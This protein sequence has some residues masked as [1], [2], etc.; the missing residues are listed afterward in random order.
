MVTTTFQ[1]S[2]TQRYLLREELGRGGMGAVFRAY[3]R[4]RGE[5]VALKRLNAP[6]DALDFSARGQGDA[7]LALANEFRLL[8]SL[9]HPNIIAVRDYGFDESGQPFYTMELLRAPQNILSVGAALPLSGKIDL[10]MQVLEALAYLHRRHILHRDLAPNNLLYAD[11]RLRVVDFGLSVLRDQRVGLAGTLPYLAPELLADGQPSEASDLYAVGVVAYELLSGFNPFRASAVSSVIENVL[12]LVPDV[13]ALGVDSPTQH[14][15]ERLLAKNPAERA[16]DAAA[17]I[18]E[19]Y[20]ATG[21]PLPPQ[22]V[23]VREGSLQAARFIGRETE[24]EQ[25]TVAL[26]HAQQAQGALW[27]IGG[28]SGVG[29][30]RLVEELRIVALVRGISV[31]RGQAV[32]SGSAL[33]QVWQAILSELTLHTTLSDLE[34]SILKP[35]VP[36]IERLLER[37]VNEPPDLEPE[38]V[39]ERFFNTVEMLFARLSRP[40]LVIL[41]DIH[42]SKQGSLELLSRVGAL[43][44]QKPLL[45]VATYREEERPDIPHLFPNARRLLLK[46]LTPEQMVRL[47]EAMI[48]I[49]NNT[50]ALQDLLQHETEGNAL[51]MIEVLRELAQL[52]G[53]LDQIGVVTLPQRLFSDG[54]QA[55]LRQRLA[56]LAEQA[57]HL[58]TL[59]AI[60]GRR[61]D[62]ALMHALSRQ[63]KLGSDIN[64]WLDLCANQAVLEFVNSEWRFTHDKLRETLLAS[65][66]QSDFAALS[67]Q[68]AQ[69][70][71][72]LYSDD[73]RQWDALAYH[74]A[75]AGELYKEAHYKMLA[76]IQAVERYAYGHAIPL[77]ERALALADA[78]DFSALQKA[79]LERNL[80]KAQEDVLEREKHYQQALALLGEPLPPQKGLTRPLI[81]AFARQFLVNRL[82][83]QRFYR[84]S[85]ERADYVQEAAAIYQDLSSDY[86]NMQRLVAGAYAVMRALNLAETLATPTAVLARAC[87][88]ACIG[89]GSVLGVHRIA[90]FYGRRALECAEQVGDQE[91]LAYVLNGI[92][93]AA[94]YR[95]DPSAK[96]LFARSAELYRAVGDYETLDIALINMAS[97]SYN[98]GD[99]KTC[100]DCLAQTQLKTQRSQFLQP[101]ALLFR[102][103]TYLIV[104]DQAQVERILA[105]VASFPEQQKTAKLQWAARAALPIWRHLLQ[106]NWA[107]AADLLRQTLAHLD[108]AEDEQEFVLSP[109][110]ELLSHLPKPDRAEY[111]AA[112]L[113]SLKTLERTA[114]PRWSLRAEYYRLHGLWLWHN[115]KR[116]AA[117]AAWRKGIM[118]AERYGLR[119][120]LLMLY[121]AYARYADER[122][123]A[124]AEALRAQ[125]SQGVI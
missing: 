99:L 5:E 57:R 112:M 122:F 9:R 68:V 52:A 22:T 86:W 100:L 17:L 120:Y 106:E 14:L 30:S 87:V 111:L 98:C 50:P 88:G 85:A 2:L 82:L 60:S 117:Q 6:V 119:A 125:L 56:R 80:G 35:F 71:E 49:A 36:E 92:G 38:R 104:G 70:I 77:L 66:S 46:R 58:L 96:A 37:S 63:A 42:W 3:D 115:G 54:V 93:I 55:V 90:R 12:R 7:A 1:V 76:G 40:A 109:G 18:T 31:L 19:Y 83:P 105:E 23:E 4:L 69:T 34:A 16:W 8:A 116:R 45:V 118:Y 15:L 73:S 107:R 26:E 25:L 47:T 89:M 27:L 67:R 95:A 72:A 81:G 11:G 121:Q 44:K 75:N 103:Q 62:M 53:R 61:L 113:P 13:S 43:A 102:L 108:E 10:I 110:L 28:E 64:A 91:T 39:R 48:G 123:R 79:R 20:D 59:A 33:Y 32:S 124:K 94:L 21:V 74:W 97:T 101:R 41:E 29:K 24:L 51:F 84:V 65:L 114:S 78:A